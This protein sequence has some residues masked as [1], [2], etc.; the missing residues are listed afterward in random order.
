VLDFGVMVRMTVALLSICFCAKG[1]FSGLA[2]PGDGSRVYFAT[3]LRQKNTTQPTYGKLFQVDS[4]G[5]KL[6]LSRDEVIPPPSQNPAQ[7]VQTNPYDLLAASFSSDGTVLAAIGSRACPYG[8]CIY[9][10][11]E[12]YTT[13][14]TAAGQEKGL[15]GQ[16]A[17]QRERAVGIRWEQ[18]WVVFSSCLSLPGHDRSVSADGKR[19]LLAQPLEESASVPITVIVNWPALLKKAAGAP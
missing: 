7:G 2:T 19:F 14:I 16:P 1:Q 13:T 3:T 10:R 17:A 4:S 11:L 5:L 8:G 6:L 15:S 18:L 9:Q 12:S